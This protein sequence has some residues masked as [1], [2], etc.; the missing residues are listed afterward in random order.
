MSQQILHLKVAM[1][2]LND[3]Q[4]PS[5]GANE[6]TVDTGKAADTSTFFPYSE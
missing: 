2:P 1:S 5:A 4:T 3:T 6:V